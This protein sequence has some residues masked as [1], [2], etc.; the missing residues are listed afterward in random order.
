MT[1]SIHNFVYDSADIHGLSTFY[2]RFTGF[3]EVWA[4]DSWVT[5]K[6]P[7]GHHLAFQQAP[8]HVPPRWPDQGEHPQQFHLDF[9][10][11]DREGD[12]AR[13]LSL[14]ATRLEG[15]GQTWSVLADPSGHPFCVCDSHEMTE[16]TWQEVAV[17]CPD[18]KTLGEF[19]AELLGYE[20]TYAGPEGSFITAQGKLPLMFQNVTGYRAP[21]WPDPAY[22][23][24]AHLDIEVDDIEAQEAKV[25]A[26]GATRLPG[27]RGTGDR[28]FRVYADPAGHPFCLEWGQ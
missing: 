18:G 13:A 4:S 1:G 9:L 23:Q 7:Q 20:M 6:S 28:G 8:E 14:G 24:Q 5:L 12:V 11:P 26:L 22:P 17:D 27:G 19:Y 16:L 15:G 21:R 25:L 10:T 3:E 2:A